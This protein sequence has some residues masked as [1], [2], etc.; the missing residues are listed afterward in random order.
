MPN[1]SFIDDFTTCIDKV[2]VHFDNI[3]VIGDLNYDL[4]KPDKS[5]PLHTVR[6]IFDFTNLIKTPTCFMKDAPALILDVIL[7]N[8]PSLLYN[9]TNSTCGIRDWQNMISCVIKGAA[10]PPNKRNIKCRSYKHFDEKV[11]SEAVGVIPFDVA[12]VF[13]DVDDIYWAHEVLLTD[14]LNDHAP[15][16]E[17]TVKT[18]Q[19]PFMNSK[20]RKAVL[21]KSMFSNKYKTRRTP[22]NWEAYRMQ[23]NL[24]TREVCRWSKDFWPTVKPFLL[25][26]GTNNCQKRD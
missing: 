13:D 8:R 19:T 26:K 14:V 21:K 3:I 17:K 4:V 5:Q 16:K 10:P 18:K 7:T 15:I 9:I 20:L 12:Y 11:F 2:H 22:A 1:A 23:R 6:D 24:C 25:N